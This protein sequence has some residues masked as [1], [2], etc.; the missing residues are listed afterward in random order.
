MAGY[1][2]LLAV[3]WD[4]HAAGVFRQNFP[5]VSVT[6]GNIAHVSVGDC[7]RG[8]GLST[9]ELDVLD[10]SPP[11]Q[12]FSTAGKRQLDDPRNALFH[13][14]VR[15]LNGLQPRV[16]VLENVPG[17]VK[18][19]MR[20]IFVE[21]LQALKACGYVVSARVLNAVY[22]GVPQT[23]QRLIV[24][25]VRNDLRCV[26]THPTAQTW[27]MSVRTAI[28]GENAPQITARDL[29]DAGIR[30][31]WQIYRV[32]TG[33]ERHRHFGLVRLKF[34]EPAPTITKDAGNTTTGLIHPTTLRKL[35][36]PEIKRLS[37]FPD[38]FTLEGTYKEQWARIG[39]SVPPFFMRAIAQHLRTTVLRREGDMA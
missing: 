27:P 6:E 14:Y 30:P 10:G 2:E 17:L 34:G 15:L 35:T 9:G 13:E 29:D 25:G 7:L 4:P 32:L 11:C 16:F 39:N 31:T 20:L 26:P 3:E 33:K 28:S 12:G 37:S 22:F 21:M 18:G 23:R 38:E 36:I 24:I 1:R 8:T 5:T 19:K